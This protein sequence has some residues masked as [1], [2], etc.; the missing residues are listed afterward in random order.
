MD[1]TSPRAES[2]FVPLGG[3]NQRIERAWV[4]VGSQVLLFLSEINRNLA[5]FRGDWNHHPI[6]RLGHDKSPID[7]RMLGE[8]RHGRYI[9]RHSMEDI[10][11]DI[12]EVYGELA[13]DPERLSQK[14]ATDQVKSIRH[15]PVET[16]K[17]TCPF[18]APEADAVF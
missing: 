9:G 8:L 18:P 13:N 3:R 4:E 10:H 6:S 1:D 17:S 7:I 16:P 2:R 14:I 5:E 11:P 12:A 15:D